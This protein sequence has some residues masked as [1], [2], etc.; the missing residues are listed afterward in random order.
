MKKSTLRLLMLVCLVSV[1][2]IA[3]KKTDDK[4]FLSYKQFIN[5]Q[6][7]KYIIY[8]LDSTVT[9][10]FGGSFVVKSYLVK[11]TIVDK[12]LDNQ[13]RESYKVF[14]LQYNPAT[15]NWDASNSFLLTPLDTK[16]EY[17]ENNLRYIKMINPVT[18]LKSWQGNNYIGQNVFNA[19]NFF[20]S[21]T[22]YYKDVNQPMQVGTF[23]F[24]NTVT[25]VQ[26]DS[27]ENRAF[28]PKN[29]SQYNKSYEVYADSVGLVYKDILSWEYQ[30]FTVPTNCKLVRP[31]AGGGLD[32]INVDCTLDATNCD[33]LRRLPNYKLTCDTIVS[34]FYYTGYGVKQTIVSHN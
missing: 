30:A 26:Y 4:P 6:V 14:R 16:I 7:G 32:T 20:S 29:Y 9:L 2:F 12:V 24:A 21:W 3:C 15:K 23:N 25:I 34:Q 19:G 33:S 8:K 11:D 1:Y 5:P 27:T 10:S 17:V 28:D 31:K 22:Y 18:E 13:N